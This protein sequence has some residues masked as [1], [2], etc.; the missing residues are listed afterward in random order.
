MIR[1]R[2]LASLMSDAVYTD[3]VMLMTSS[4]SEN[5]EYL[6]KSTKSFMTFEGFKIVYGE[7]TEDCAEFTK[8]LDNNPVCYSY[9]YKSNGFI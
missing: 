7:K 8:M 6:F 4:L 2:T 5:K 1:K 3:I 9:E